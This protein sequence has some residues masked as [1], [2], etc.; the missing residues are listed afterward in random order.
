M[1]EYKL[2]RLAERCRSHLSQTDLAAIA[3]G[4][5][6]IRFDADAGFVLSPAA[7]CPPL[8]RIYP[9]DGNTEVPDTV[10]GL[11]PLRAGWVSLAMPLLLRAH[12]DRAMA[13]SA[14]PASGVTSLW[15]VKTFMAH[16]QPQDAWDTIADMT[17]VEKTNAI[18]PNIRLIDGKTIKARDVDAISAEVPFIAPDDANWQAVMQAIASGRAQDL[19]TLLQAHPHLVSARALANSNPFSNPM[20]IAGMTANVETMAVLK[21]HGAD[22]DFPDRDM[23]TALI[24]AARRGRSNSCNIW[25]HRAHRAPGRITTAKPLRITSISP[26]TNMSAA[27]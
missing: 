1:N 4:E 20:T 11:L 3:A 17:D 14:P 25:S 26:R 10:A 19:D 27:S 23:K 6:L 13:L 18:H 15:M 21:T 7:D 16:G 12:A 5:Q 24:L 2:L 9:L 22:L 8:M